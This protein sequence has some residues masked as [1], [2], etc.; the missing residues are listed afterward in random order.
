MAEPG[1]MMF[2]QVRCP[3]PRRNLCLRPRGLDPSKQ[4]ID[5]LSH[6]G[7]FVGMI[8]HISGMHPA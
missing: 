5:A 7:T 1:N 2:L 4:Y 3:S 6:A 8:A